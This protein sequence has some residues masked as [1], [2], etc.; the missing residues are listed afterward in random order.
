MPKERTVASKLANAVILIALEV[1]ALVLLVNN[2][3]MQQIWMMRVSHGFAAKTWG[4]SQDISN[5][6]SLKK[7]NDELAS[8]NHR[9]E[10]LVRDYRQTLERSD[11][12]L[13]PVLADDGFLYTPAKVIKSGTNSQH[14]YLILDKGRNDGISENSGIITSKGVIGIVDAVSDHYSYAIS[15]LNTEVSISSRLGESGTVGPLSWD[16]M[17]PDGAL[18]KEISLQYK[19]APG[20]TVYTSGYSVLFPP[21]IPLGTAGEARIINGATN[22]IKIKLFQNHSAVK[23][24]TIVRNT[25][26]AE[27]QEIEEGPQEKEGNKK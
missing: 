24:V 26:A 10:A 7:Q 16:G 6:F 19:F 1:T 17:N 15:F 13:E 25:R 2:G 21:D 22:E 14:N 12:S 3:K 4:V 9:L 11:K 20:D 5:Y 27:I 18:L 8:E 23:Y